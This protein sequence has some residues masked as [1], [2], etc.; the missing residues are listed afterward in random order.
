[1][2]QAFG[3]TAPGKWIAANSWQYGFIVRYPDGLEPVTG[4]EYEPWHLRFIGPRAG[5]RDAHHRHPDPGAVLRTAGRPRL[6]RL[7]VTLDGPLGS[8]GGTATER[9]LSS[10]FRVSPIQTVAASAPAL[11]APMPQNPWIRPGNRRC[12]TR[13]P[14]AASASA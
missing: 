3:A 6:P 12:S 8:A 10:S 1:M 11:V 7:I 4:Y 5:D 2:S 13:T 14:A 9:Q